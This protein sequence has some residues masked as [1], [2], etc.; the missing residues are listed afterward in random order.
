MIIVPGCLDFAI[1]HAHDAIPE[2]FKDHHFYPWNLEATLMRT[3]PEENALL[4]RQIAER[5]NNAR[6]PVAILLPLRGLS[7]MDLEGQPY[8][9][10]EAVQALFSAIRQPLHCTTSS[11]SK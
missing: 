6:G 1:Y 8:W 2:K 7:L 4:G 5:A 11:Q 9:Q 10:P 3:T